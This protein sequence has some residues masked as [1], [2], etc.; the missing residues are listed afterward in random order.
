MSLLQLP[1]E[2]LLQV[3]SYLEFVSDLGSL[4]QCHSLLYNLLKD[5]VDKLLKT[6]QSLQLLAWA[7][8]NGKEMCVRKLLNAGTLPNDSF[9]RDNETGWCRQCDDPMTIAAK[10]GHVDVVRMFLD[11][12]RDPTPAINEK[13]IMFSIDITCLVRFGNP[14]SVAV[15]EGHISVVSLLI[16]RGFIKRCAEPREKKRWC[17]LSL[18]L[19]VMKGHIPII[20]L[21]LAGG[22]DPNSCWSGK[23]P[24]D[25]LAS[26]PATSTTM[27][28]IRLLVDAGANLWS[29]CSGQYA[30]SLALE[31]GNE[32]FI[33][34][35]F[36]QAIVFDTE[37]I[38]NMVDEVAGEHNILASF[39]LKKIDLDHTINFSRGA[40]SKLLCGAVS[41]GFEDLMKRL[42]L[43]WNTVFEDWTCECGHRDLM[44]L[45]IAS[46]HIGMIE[47]LLKYGGSLTEAVSYP[48]IIVEK[49]TDGNWDFD[50]CPPSMIVALDRGHDDVVKYLINKGFDVVFASEHGNALFNRALYLG[51]VEIL[52]MLF[53]S[54]SPS[55]ED[56][57]LSNDGLSIQLAVLGGEAVFKLLLEHGVQLQPGYVEHDRAFVCAALL[58][59]VPILKIFL[60]AGFSLEA[61]GLNYGTFGLELTLDENRGVTLLALAAQAKDRNAAEAAVDL[62]LEHGVQVNQLT[63]SCNHTPLLCTVSGV[64]RKNVGATKYFVEE[65]TK[66]KADAHDFERERNFNE[67]SDYELLATKLLL[68]KGADPL[69]MNRSGKSA[70]TAAAAACRN[71]IETVKMLLE[72]VDPNVPISAIKSHILAATAP[73][74]DSRGS[75]WEKKR[76]SL[77]MQKTLWHYYWRKVYPCPNE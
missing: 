39:L 21:L 9:T 46:G 62:L 24:L 2:L 42:R 69:F 54:S 33:Y 36:E 52:Q 8:A 66:T 28:I 53:E 12:G 23:A 58:A 31:T 15:L 29:K 1:V 4:Y 65:I 19:A 30:F 11:Y 59:N 43:A 63:G 67:T 3:S 57:A 17:N 10:R 41:G 7:A 37:A 55:I 25:Y 51:K 22:C 76:P 50:L 45:A 73:F 72:Y 49:D 35:A 26:I 6:E 61:Q 16:E 18:C 71:D 38:L 75:S 56:I 47:L 13:S 14:L 40:R 34:Y 68:E 20:K 5:R 32:P 77:A 27:E 64:A 60:D 48:A 70:L 74:D 44:A